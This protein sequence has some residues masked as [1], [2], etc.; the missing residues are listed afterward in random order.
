MKAIN[1]RKYDF[2]WRVEYMTLPFHSIW[3]TKEV[4][5]R[6]FIA[7][8]HGHTWKV[9]IGKEERLRLGVVGY[10]LLKSSLSDFIRNAK[11]LIADGRSLLHRVSRQELRRLDVQELYKKYRL[12]VGHGRKLWSQYFRTE[13]FCYDLVDEKIRNGG[14]EAKLLRARVKRMQRIKLRLREQLNEIGFGAGIGAGM[15][16]E[17]AKRLKLKRLGDW[18]YLELDAALQGKHANVANRSTWVVGKF[19]DWRIITGQKA[20]SIIKNLERGTLPESRNELKG[21]I[22][23]LGKYRGRVKIIP[24]DLT[25]DHARLIAKMKRGDVLVTGSTGPELILA[26]KKAG[27]I[28]TE[29]GGITSHAAIISRELGI[30]CVIGTKIATE[31][32]KDGDRVEVDATKGIVR[33]LKKA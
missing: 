8:Y 28:V 13:Y 23:N 20:L 33:I 18:S 32:L 4:Q 17:I 7:T 3:V 5:Q 16:R 19:S 30:P 25:A 31:V 26:C 14:Q 11:K 2:L 27:A 9:Y 10:R 22:G 29:E 24:F 21:Q 1:P 15:F 12:L 6:D